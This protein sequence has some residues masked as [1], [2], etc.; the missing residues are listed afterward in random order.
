[1]FQAC[2]GSQ[3]ANIQYSETV[4]M[5][6]PSLARAKRCHPFGA[7]RLLSHARSVSVKVTPMNWMSS[8]GFRQLSVFYLLSKK[9][10]NIQVNQPALYRTRKLGN[11]KETRLLCT[12]ERITIGTVNSQ[13]S[14]RVSNKTESVLFGYV[15][16]QPFQKIT[17]PHILASLP[18][19]GY[20]ASSSTV[21]KQ[22]H[23]PLETKQH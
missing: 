22:N 14:L 12:N 10:W 11:Q 18:S 2:F 13:V 4:A 15:S 5:V 9:T 20:C 1:M 17:H 3:R 23:T 19:F 6:T 16:T 21:T 7:P 8:I